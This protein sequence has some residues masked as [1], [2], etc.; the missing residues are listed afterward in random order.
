MFTQGFGEVITDMLTMDPAFAGLPAASAILDTSNYTFQAVTYGKDAEGF[1]YHGHSVST[2]QYIDDD[3]SNDA[4]G[5]NDGFLV[6][7]NYS[8][9]SAVSS[10]DVSATYRQFSGLEDWRVPGGAYMDKPYNPIPQYPA[11]T[12]L[13]LESKSTKT[14]NA[15]SFSSAPLLPDTGHYANPAVDEN[16]SSIW[17]V[18]GGFPPSG[19]TVKY[20]LFSANSSGVNG[21][22]SEPPSAIASYTLSGVYNENGVVDKNGFVTISPEPTNSLLSS[23]AVPLQGGGLEK[24][25]CIFSSQPPGL[26]NTI[27]KAEVYLAVVPQL[28]D[29]AALALFGGVKHLGVWCLDLKSM[30]A[31]GLTPPY[32]WNH[33]NNIR[34]YKLVA[35]VTFWDNLMMHFDYL[36]PPL[37]GYVLQQ[38]NVSAFNYAGIEILNSNQLRQE[39]N[40]VFEG[41]STGTSIGFGDSGYVNNGP[42]LQL[43]FK[44]N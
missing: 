17:N 30:L 19:N 29:A 20:I 32:A 39:P 6:V 11:L 23:V 27:N 8:E 7:I 34:K 14:T 15:S 24:G 4:S 9:S 13:R 18:V 43:V 1:N 37:Y 12:D 28:G 16:L 26:P 21:P 2:T 35:K 33:L 3:S 5:Y 25:P 44:F 36:A 22:F 40:W 41:G 31:S 42:L 10:Y 38:I